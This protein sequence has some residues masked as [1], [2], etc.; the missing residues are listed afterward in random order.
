MK[1]I[2]VLKWWEVRRGQACQH[3]RLDE[4]TAPADPAGQAAC[5][6]GTSDAG[7]ERQHV[8][9]SEAQRLE[10]R[11]GEQNENS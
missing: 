3:G 4:A 6:R 5:H 1:N 8:E 11:P 10:E 9:S 2:R 7:Q